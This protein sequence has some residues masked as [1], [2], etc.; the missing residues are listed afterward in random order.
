MTKKEK[1]NELVNSLK[2]LGVQNIATGTHPQ[3]GGEEIVIPFGRLPNSNVDNTQFNFSILDD[4]FV[5]FIGPLYKCD[6]NSLGKGLYI[7]NQINQRPLGKFYI[8]DEGFV[9]MKTT[10]F[11]ID[12]SQQLLGEFIKYFKNVLNEEFINHFKDNIG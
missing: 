3:T 1:S 4:F 9:C 5:I 11:L 12:N 2:E 7:V 8:D 6:N 10:E